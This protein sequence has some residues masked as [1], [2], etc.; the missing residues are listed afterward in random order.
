MSF[1]SQ[2]MS[3]MSWLRSYM[4]LARSMLRVRFQWANVPG[5]PITSTVE[6]MEE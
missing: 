6:A 2:L 4:T 5:S 1:M 3:F